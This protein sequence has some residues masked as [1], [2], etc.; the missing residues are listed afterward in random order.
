MIENRINT[1]QKRTA[2]GREAVGKKLVQ[3]IALVDAANFYAFALVCSV[4]MEELLEPF[5]ELFLELLLKPFEIVF[6]SGYALLKGS[7]RERDRLIILD[8]HSP[9]E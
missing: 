7:P 5:A 3:G 8:L 1:P 4:H 9:A 6:E 2:E